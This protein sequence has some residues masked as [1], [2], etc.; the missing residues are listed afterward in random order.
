MRLCTARH[1]MG[2]NCPCSTL[3]KMIHD[4]DID[5]CPN[6]TFAKWSAL[7]DKT[8]G[9]IWNRKVVDPSKVSARTVKLAAISLAA[10]TG[11]KAKL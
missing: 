9:L 8:P 7:V 5:K 11:A 4:L 2:R 1:R 6:S 10:A 3:C